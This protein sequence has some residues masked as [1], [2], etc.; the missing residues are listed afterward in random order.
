[1]N[2]IF[3]FLLF[4][5]ICISAGNSSILKP[6]QVCYLAF[7]VIIWLLL[8]LYHML[9]LAVLIIFRLIKY[10]H[11][12]KNVQKYAFIIHIFWLIVYG[13]AF[14]FMLIGFIYD[15]AMIIDGKIA[16][17]VYPV[18]Y[19]VVCLVYVILSFFDYIFKEKAL[20]LIW[21]KRRR[22]KAPHNSDQEDNEV[23]QSSENENVIKKSEEKDKN[24]SDKQKGD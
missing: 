18:I 11:L 12:V 10:I 6:F 1:M 9:K 8:T 22:E 20:N 17:I 7:S 19:F 24:E 13:L 21:K 4:L 5:I 2:F 3:N 14:L 23:R 15:I 16:T